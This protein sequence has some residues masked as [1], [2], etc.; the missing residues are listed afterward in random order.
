MAIGLCECGCGDAADG[1]FAPGHAS[2]A[3]RMLLHLDGVLDYDEPVVDFLHRR[4]YGRDRRNLRRAYRDRL[5]DDAP[6]DRRLTADPTRP[7]HRH[8]APRRQER[9]QEDRLRRP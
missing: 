1:S 7:A 4:G 9:P 5:F 6:S 8:R 3:L 2:E